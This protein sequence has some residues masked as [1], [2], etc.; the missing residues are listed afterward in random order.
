MFPLFTVHIIPFFTHCAVSHTTS[1]Q[2]F[3]S[4]CFH[5]MRSF[6]S[7]FQSVRRSQFFSTTSGERPS[8]PIMCLFI[9]SKGFPLYCSLEQL[10][11]HR[12]LKT[13]DDLI[14]YPRS[15]KVVIRSSKFELIPDSQVVSISR[16]F[17]NGSRKRVGFPFVWSGR[18]T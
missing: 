1:N 2:S 7:H 5:K 9:L 15:S 18:K 17:L 8:P 10:M 11:L 16:V 6:V 12:Q 14:R 3:F 4:R 13:L